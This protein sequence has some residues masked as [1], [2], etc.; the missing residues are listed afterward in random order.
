MTTSLFRNVDLAKLSEVRG[1]AWQLCCFGEFIRLGLKREYVV[2]TGW[3]RTWG[4]FAWIGQG[5]DKN[6]LNL[7]WKDKYPS[8]LI[9]FLRSFPDGEARLHFGYA[10]PQGV[11]EHWLF[12][13]K[14]GRCLDLADADDADY[15]E[16]MTGL[17]VRFLIPSYGEVFVASS[18]DI[19]DFVPKHENGGIL[20]SKVMIDPYCEAHR[21]RVHELSWHLRHDHQC[22]PTID[23]HDELTESFWRDYCDYLADEVPCIPY[24]QILHMAGGNPWNL[25]KKDAQ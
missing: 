8:P 9:G 14:A 22:R 11:A 16:Q 4:H 17:P 7:N 6:R 5:Q 23:R 21:D 25:V 1:Y 15:Y 20:D 3:E 13:C 18:E 19:R 10:L 12:D 2:H 24:A